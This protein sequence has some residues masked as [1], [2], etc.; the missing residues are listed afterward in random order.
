MPI[1]T[2]FDAAMMQAALSVPAVRRLGGGTVRINDSGSPLRAVGRDAVVYELRAPDGRILALRS[3]LRPDSHR[4]AALA[5]RY[6]ALGSDPRLEVLRGPSGALP[7]GIQWILEGVALPG[8]DH[9]RRSA[10]VMAMERVPGRTLIRAVDRLCHERESEP[11]AH[12]ADAWLNLVTTL[13]AAG[14]SHGDLTADNL[15]VRPDGSIALVDLDTAAWPSYPVPAIRTS[16]THGYAHP[17]GAPLNTPARDRFPALIIWAS[18][19]VLARHPTLRPQWGDPPDEYGGVLLWTHTDVSRA[20]RSPLFATLDA[21]DD[22]VLAPLFEVVRR[23]IRFP[24][25]DTPSLSEIAERLEPLG[26]P[27]FAA[28]QSTLRRTRTSQPDT[29]PATER[30]SVPPRDDRAIRNVDPSP[31]TPSSREQP[32]KE[33]PIDLSR[34]RVAAER[35]QRRTAARQ[36]GAAVAARDT[37]TAVRLWDEQRGMPEAGIYAVALHELVTY[38]AAAAMDRAIRRRDDAGLLETVSTAER[39]GVALSREMRTET[40]SAR[41]RVS[42]RAALDEAVSRRDLQAIARLAI[43]GQLDDLA[44]LD[45]AQERIVAQALAWPALERALATDDDLAI[46]GAADEALWDEDGALP[47]NARA[48]VA[49]AQRRTRWADDVRTAL[50]RRDSARLR[51]LLNSAPQGAEQRLTEV[52]SR[53]ILRISTREAA[54]SRLAR[55][56]R[57][58]PDREVVAAFSEFETAGAPFSEVLDWAAVRGVVDRISL[59]DALRTAASADPPDTEKLARLLPAARAALGDPDAEPSQDWLALEHYVL[60]AAHLGR[61]REA[62]DSGDDA[63]I[64]SAADPDS[65]GAISLLAP[66]ER[67]RVAEA[68]TA[69]RD[70]GRERRRA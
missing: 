5:E 59:A 55:A 17:R 25:D 12:L 6:T 41:R 46:A 4:D 3:H 39:S 20:H 30:S 15:I 48:R 54:V 9:H 66:D 44:R 63:S 36:L 23:A 58:G 65:Y 22:D 16:G 42:V 8:V 43:S 27:R 34:A 70:L 24:P 47:A 40:R 10:P 13:E 67:A 26:L 21:L 14:F 33:R 7:H 11:L 60:R 61:L 31:A 69:R 38:D 49:L 1:I 52:E 2:E 68:L 51:D 32:P 53:R 37:S 35:E 64:A 56:L 57:D 62:I 50:R 45:H 18:L 19:R 29:R 28:S